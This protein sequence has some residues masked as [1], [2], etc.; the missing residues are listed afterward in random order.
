MSTVAAAMQ[1]SGSSILLQLEQVLADHG[2]VGISERARATPAEPLGLVAERLPARSARF[3]LAREPAVFLD[4]PW[5]LGPA[6]GRSRGMRRWVLAGGLLVLAGLLLAQS[7]VAPAARPGGGASASLY[8]VNWQGSLGLVRVDRDTLRPLAGRRVALSEGD[9]LG[10]SFAPDRS[11]IVLGSA[12]RG[13]TLRLID[14]RAMRALGDV[15]VTRRGSEVA[16]AWTGPRRVLAVVVVPGCCGAGDTI[17][18][19][20]DAGR[21]RVVWRRTLG[22][23]LQAGERFRRSLLLV[24]GPR[25]RSIGP[26]RLV[27]VGPRGGTRSAPLPEI[28]SGSEPDGRGVTQRWDPG[29]AVDRSGG[30]AFVV[31]A[32]APL[33]EVHLSTLRVRSH[34]LEPQARAA[35]DA[36]AGPTRHALWL[37]RGMLAVTGSDSHDTSDDPEGGGRPTPAGLTLIDTR[38]WRART[39]DPRTTDAVLVSGTVLASSFLFD[40]RGQTT[41]GSGL[42]G[43]TL[44]GRRKFH[45]F[46]GAWIASVQ[47]LG[48]RALIGAQN[49]IAL[50]DARTGHMLR[51]YRR[52]TTSLLAGDAPFH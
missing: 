32:G 38:R 30:R 44:D 21:R 35:D 3:V 43:Y 48:N 29:L 19:G 34:P 7:G 16:T 36:V 25:G 15:R 1:S 14:L 12:A 41:S 13:A 52:L 42:T 27:Q 20:I 31:Q 39:I 28:R 37:G 18:A 23:S 40:P 4:C 33:A 6:D 5:D 22:G 10:W 9:H 2:Q 26:S 24:L 50:I 51:S 17:V 47:P 11:R 49:E 8:G 46:A 45:R